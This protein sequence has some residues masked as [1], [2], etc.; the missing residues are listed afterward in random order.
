MA[1][2]VLLRRPDGQSPPVGRRARR[3]S[4]FIRPTPVRLAAPSCARRRLGQAPAENADVG[5]AS[6]LRDQAGRA[7]AV[8]KQSRLTGRIMQISRPRACRFETGCSGHAE[9][10]PLAAVLEASWRPN[11]RRLERVEEE[12][13]ADCGGVIASTAERADSARASTS[14]G[15]S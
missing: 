11:G 7:N 9:R 8:V 14:S 13:G 12:S 10:A 5:G 6:T 4:A 2:R 1:R 3:C 15:C